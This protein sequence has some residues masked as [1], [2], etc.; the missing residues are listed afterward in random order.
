MGLD[1]SHS[2][3]SGPYGAFDEFREAVAVAAGVDMWGFGADEGSGL[4]IFL[5][6]PDDHGSLTPGECDLV[7]DDLERLLPR[8]EAVEASGGVIAT[9]D[10]HVESE[11][12][13]AAVT[14]KFIAGCRKASAN[15]EDLEFY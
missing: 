8:I 12:G 1:C 14:K 11:G 2:A 7:A 6:H 10:G 4:H 13:F 5:D 15:G 3:Y 9:K